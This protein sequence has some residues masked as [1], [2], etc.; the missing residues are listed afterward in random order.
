[1][2]ATG[3]CNAGASESLEDT[4]LDPWLHSWVRGDKTIDK[5]S[6]IRRCDHKQHSCHKT[7]TIAGDA[8][9]LATKH[10][11]TAVS[12]FWGEGGGGGGGG[13]FHAIPKLQSL[14][15]PSRSD[16]S[17]HKASS[18]GGS[19]NKSAQR[20][21]RVTKARTHGSLPLAPNQEPWRAERF[22]SP[23]MSSAGW[24]RLKLPLSRACVAWWCSSLPGY[25]QR[26]TRMYNSS[27]EGS[28]SPAGRMSAR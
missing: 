20:T 12:S 27:R 8:G 22:G 7:R 24:P 26:E 3:L 10:H 19:L 13:G 25:R 16:T 23:V 17:T 2:P 18:Q 28:P 15:S 9:P 4:A 21:T 6:P 11:L 5:P 1:M 14:F